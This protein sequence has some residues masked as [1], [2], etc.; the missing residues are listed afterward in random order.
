MK[1]FEVND[2]RFDA[3]LEL[4]CDGSSLQYEQLNIFLD[5]SN[6]LLE[7]RVVTRW[8]LANLT[9]Q[10]AYVEIEIGKEL[11]Q[12]LTSKS[13]RFADIVAE[14]PRRFSLIYDYSTGSVEICHLDN[15]KIVWET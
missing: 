7:G 12:W 3:A 1:A 15:E 4:F 11:F 13:T 8:Q 5:R 9:D 2:Q 6:C 10:T 14:I